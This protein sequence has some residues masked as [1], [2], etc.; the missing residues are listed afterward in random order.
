M[1]L[2]KGKKEKKRLEESY[3]ILSQK[4]FIRQDIM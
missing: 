4:R 1:P 3:D 2:G